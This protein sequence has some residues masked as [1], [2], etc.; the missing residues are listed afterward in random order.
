VETRDL[1][2]ALEDVS[3]RSL[4]RLF[5]Q[6]VY[7]PGHPE[8]EIDV[9]WDKGILTIALKQVQPVTD[10]V[11]ASFEIA[12]D[13]DLGDESGAVARRQVRVTERQQSFALPAPVRP[14]FVV[15][16]PDMRI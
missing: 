8:L 3:G 1:Q 7:K 5:E 2:R 15:I 12:L 16:D 6:W 14:A 11:P 13:L 4:G 10:G 9:G